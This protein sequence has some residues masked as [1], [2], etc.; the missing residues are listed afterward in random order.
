MML[1]ENQQLL[2]F[3]S[4]MSAFLCIIMTIIQ[5]K[6]SQFMAKFRVN[7]NLCL[8]YIKRFTLFV[9][10]F[11]ILLKN[12]TVGVLPVCNVKSIIVVIRNVIC[13]QTGIS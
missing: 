6:M 5:G 3:L 12:G 8:C 9:A 11:I 1:I 7:Y 4:I 2:C 13:I 10:K